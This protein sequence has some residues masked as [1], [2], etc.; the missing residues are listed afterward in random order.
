MRWPSLLSRASKKTET[1]KELAVLVP[2]FQLGARGEQLAAERLRALGYALVVSNFTINVGR[3]LRGAVVST[4]IDLI[5]YDGDTLCFV[6]VKTRASDW[7]APPEANVD[8]RKRRQIARA[9]RA[10]RR[11]F[12]LADAPYRYDVV[13]VLIPSDSFEDVTI[14]PRVEV[15]RNFWRDDMFRKRRWSDHEYDS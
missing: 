10:Y 9:A 4:E 6:E 2:H 13:S 11:M 8:L 15:L 5:A 3:N 14:R 12:G 7:F 1:T